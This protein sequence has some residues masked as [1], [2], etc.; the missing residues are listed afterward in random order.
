MS[1]RRKSSELP[2]EI[3]IP[4][5]EDNNDLVDSN[6]YYSIKKLPEDVRVIEMKPEPKTIVLKG[7]M[8]ILE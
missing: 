7:K 8:I 2:K 6:E 4:K 1:E 3:E 5:N